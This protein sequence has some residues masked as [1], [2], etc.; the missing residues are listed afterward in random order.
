MTRSFRDWISHSFIGA[1]SAWIAAVAIGDN[2]TEKRAL[3]KAEEFSAPTSVVTDAQLDG[4]LRYEGIGFVC[5]DCH[6][7]FCSLG[8]SLHQP[9][10]GWRQRESRCSHCRQAKEATP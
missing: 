2:A 8:A 7:A 10:V 9:A 3:A 4:A 6:G 5:E 1:T